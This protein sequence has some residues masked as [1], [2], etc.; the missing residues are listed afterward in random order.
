[1]TPIKRLWNLLSGYK[2]DLRQIYL[3]AILN[4]LI[5]LS[6]PLGIQAIINYIQ[7]GE[8]TTSWIILVIFVLVGIAIT[9]VLQVFQL[10]IVENI[11][12]DLFAKSAFEFAYRL[13][14]I[15]VLA[16]DKI[17]APEL[18]NRFFDT[19][20]VQKGLPKILIDFSLASFQIIFGLILLT[21]YS[22]YFIILGFSLVLVLWLIF[23]FTGQKGIDTSLKESKYKYKVAHWLEE[24]A[25]VNRSFK[26]NAF[27]KLHLKSTDD[28]VVKYLTN[29]EAHFGVL[30]NQFKLFISFKIFIAAG[31]LVLGGVLVFNEQMNIGQFVAAEIIIILIINSVEKIIRVVD[32]IYDVLTALEKIGFVTD[33]KLDDNQG[34]LEIHKDSNI[35]LKGINLS[36]SFPDNSNKLIDNLS[37][38]IPQGAKVLIDGKSGSGKSTLIKILAG[39]HTPNE[40]Q[41]YLNSIPFKNY[42]KEKLFQNISYLP[43]TNQLFEG[44]IRDNITLGKNI[45]DKVINEI[46]DLLGLE[47]FIVHQK[48]GLLS[49]VDSIGRR[50]PR[51]IVQ[52]IH[53][54]RA[55]V[56][57]PKL[58]LLEDPLQFIEEEYKQK[59][60]DYIF[61]P[62]NN[63][64][65]LVVGDYYYWKESCTDIL[66][67]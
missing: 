65:V 16:I 7:T 34:T 44:T 67:L 5:S 64:T 61:N 2:T 46:I 53:I 9:G 18:V 47:S 63:M 57:Q 37:F 43:S 1:M 14:K 48:N 50:L 20:T 42:E 62:T 17:H 40:G 32:T 24:I 21:I 49:K 6:L 12:Q 66:H 4:G 38:S 26:L 39:I 30:L 11:Q 56:S 29:R 19:L 31:L 28:L 8:M 22:P 51:S 52:K 3:Y 15:D 33:L 59:I 58:L 10:R 35:E 25:R 41:L 60:I 55:L 54:A 13:P 36:F 27:E 45:E 23:R